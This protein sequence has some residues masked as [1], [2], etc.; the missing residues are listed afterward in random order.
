MDKIIT[1]R[2]LKLS[3]LVSWH[4]ASCKQVLCQ[5]RGLVPQYGLPLALPML[6]AMVTQQQVHV[7]SSQQV[8]LLWS[9]REHTVQNA[10]FTR[11][12]RCSSKVSTELHHEPLAD[13]L[14]PC[15]KLFTSKSYRTANSMACPASRVPYLF[16]SLKHCDGSRP[17]SFGA[18]MRTLS[19]GTLQ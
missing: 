16:L 8:L 19:L 14:S 15:E 1:H 10:L 7:S 4:V 11:V 13:L 12:V 9:P 2:L 6:Q 5:E 18:L 17:S 3:G